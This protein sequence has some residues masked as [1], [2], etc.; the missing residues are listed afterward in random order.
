MIRRGVRSGGSEAPF[1]W[2]HNTAYY[3]WILK[4]LSACRDI[5]DVGCGDGSLARYLSEH[6]KQVIGIDPSEYCIRK[7]Q[8]HQKPGARFFRCS[9]EDFDVPEESFDAI[10]FL[11]SIHHMDFE[12][13]IRKAKRL[14]KENGLLVIV[15]L[16]RSASMIDCFVDLFRVIPSRLASW[17][18]HEKTT[19]DLGV[20]VSYSYPTMAEIKAAAERHLDHAA[21]RYGL[22][23]RYLLTWTE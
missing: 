21:L 8:Q 4:K 11:A 15:G 20:P 13:A 9:F 14:L 3:K 18:H 1:Y 22:Y 5:L 19:E 23:L 10:V 17:I 16:A 2:N 7:A 12:Q 6:G